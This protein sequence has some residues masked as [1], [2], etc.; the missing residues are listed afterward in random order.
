VSPIFVRPV[1]E[2][3]E[4]DRLIRHL[5]LKYKKKFDAVGN[6]GDEQVAPVKM[7]TTTYYP[8]VVLTGSIWSGCSTTRAR[9]PDGP[10]RRPRSPLDRRRRRRP[11]P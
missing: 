8:D 7:G 11:S 1:R 2:Q 3:L 6:T 5:V 4:H 9:R 10:R